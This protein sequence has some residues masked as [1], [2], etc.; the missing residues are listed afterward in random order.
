MRLVIGVSGAPG[1]GKG[2]FAEKLK[3]LYPEGMVRVLKLSGAEQE[4]PAA[5]REKIDAYRARTEGVRSILLVVGRKVI[6]H[7][8]FG[9]D[10]CLLID[11]DADLR[12]LRQVK[13]SKS[14]REGFFG[15]YMKQRKA[16]SEALLEMKRVASFIVKN[17][18]SVDEFDAAPFADWL[19]NHS[20][21]F[22]GHRQTINTCCP[23]FDSSKME[24]GKKENLFVI[25]GPLLH[26]TP[27]LMSDAPHTSSSIGGLIM[28]TTNEFYARKNTRQNFCN[29]VDKDFES[30]LAKDELLYHFQDKK[31]GCH[32]GIRKKD[33]E[34]PYFHTRGGV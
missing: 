2:T 12:L 11:T 25:S 13:S 19:P 9:F 7:K 6:C 5:I 28:Y 3:R 17:N 8:E 24:G 4:D 20:H 14:T 34:I 33:V 29:V 15:D 16:W 23:S 31:T 1:A 26:T 32:Y 22:P 30:F 27:R 21:L 18:G 10:A